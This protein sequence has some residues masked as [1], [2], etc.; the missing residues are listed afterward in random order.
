MRYLDKSDKFVFIIIPGFRPEHVPKFKIIKSDK[1]EVF[2]SLDVLLDEECL[3]KIETAI[4]NKITI[5]KYLSDFRILK[6]TAYKKKVCLLVDS[7][8]E[9]EVKLKKNKK[10]L[11][12]VDSDKEEEVKPNK[13]KL[14]IENSSSNSQGSPSPKSKQTKKD[15]TKV[16]TKN[17]T[18]RNK[19]IKQKKLLI[20][21]SDSD[22]K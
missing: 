17:K 4:D 16:K 21:E 13:K 3:R 22:T 11:I 6:K 15:V 9:E 1:K 20:I 18:K 14:I 10:K 8:K 2:I 5:E 19:G 12:I 7:D